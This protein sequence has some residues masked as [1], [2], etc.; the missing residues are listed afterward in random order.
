MEIVT[1]KNA[2]GFTYK[3]LAFSFNPNGFYSVEDMTKTLVLNEQI[4][5]KIAWE[6]E[7]AKTIEDQLQ[8][9]KP[10]ELFLTK[11]YQFGYK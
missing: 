5:S 8:M 9:L 6:I 11:I 4:S 10:F 2:N 7:M 3:R 1:I